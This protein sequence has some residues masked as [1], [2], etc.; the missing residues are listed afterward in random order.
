MVPC[1]LSNFNAP[2]ICPDSLPE[3]IYGTYGDDAYSYYQL[4]ISH[5]VESSENASFCASTTEMSSYPILK[6]TTWMTSRLSLNEEVWNNYYTQFGL[7]DSSTLAAHV[8]FEPT[9]YIQYQPA[10]WMSNEVGI[11][12]RYIEKD[13]VLDPYSGSFV[14]LYFR[15]YSFYTKEDLICYSLIDWITDVGGIFSSTFAFF[16]F[17]CSFYARSIKKFDVVYAEKLAKLEKQR[18]EKFVNQVVDASRFIL[19]PEEKVEARINTKRKSAMLS[20]ASVPAETE[21]API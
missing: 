2:G 1:N 7:S 21:L 10:P 18:E 12:N 15:A 5:C 16:T 3:Q 8:Y 13:A 4:Q 19:N 9:Q 20:A 17:L 14:K 6:L 11:Y